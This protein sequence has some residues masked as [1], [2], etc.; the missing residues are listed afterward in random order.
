MATAQYWADLS[1]GDHFTTP[2]AA[3]TRQEIFEF[4]RN[5]DPQPYHL[6]EEAAADSVFGGLC[7]SGWHVCAVMM[8]LL[9]D[10]LASQQVSV[11][12]VSEVEGLRWLKPV[13]ANDQLTA[14]ITLADKREGEQA[15]FGLAGFN[16]EIF[17]Q[18]D[19]RVITL[20]TE[21][22]IATS[23]ATRVDAVGTTHHE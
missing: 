9:T 3:I 7:A 12:G 16:L 14:N 23:A 5:Y 15:A 6:D 8:R 10:A 21:L 22:M 4:A 18:R 2:P 1:V 17:N 19:E 11:L 20:H 13:F